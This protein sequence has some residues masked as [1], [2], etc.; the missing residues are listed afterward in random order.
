MSWPGLK[1]VQSGVKLLTLLKY[2]GNNE[3]ILLSPLES[4]VNKQV[5]VILE[6][7]SQFIGAINR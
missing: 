2:M 1:W 7:I 3:V 5:S 4:K 6:W